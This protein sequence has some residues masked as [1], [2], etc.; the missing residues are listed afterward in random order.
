M[1]KLRILSSFQ[2]PRSPIGVL[3]TPSRQSPRHLPIEPGQ[4]LTGVSATPGGSS[5][6]GPPGVLGTPRPIEPDQ[7]LTRSPSRKSPR[8]RNIGPGQY[9]PDESATPGSSQ[10]RPSLPITPH[11]EPG[12]RIIV[13]HKIP[14]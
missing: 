12:Q 14:G 2:S 8:K 11:V 6:R 4:Y 13:A 9:L 5:P 7:Y 10:H 3:G 1:S